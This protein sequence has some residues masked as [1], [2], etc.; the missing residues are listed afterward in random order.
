MDKHEPASGLVVSEEPIPAAQ[1]RDVT[2]SDGGG[3]DGSDG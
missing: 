1:D 3:G 2:P